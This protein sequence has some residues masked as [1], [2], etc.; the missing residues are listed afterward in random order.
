MYGRSDCGKSRVIYE[1]IKERLASINRV[2]IINPRPLVGIESHRIGLSKLMN[3]L[4]AKD[5]VI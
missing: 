2:F 4:T 5:A 1:I 3:E